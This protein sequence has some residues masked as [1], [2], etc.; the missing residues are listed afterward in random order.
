MTV[1]VLI[2]AFLAGFGLGFFVGVRLFLRAT[3][4]PIYYEVRRF[5]GAVPLNVDV[6]EY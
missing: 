1:L 4:E 3:D 5:K 6:Y 2:L